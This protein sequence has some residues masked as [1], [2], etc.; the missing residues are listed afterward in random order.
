[1]M[2]RLTAEGDFLNECGAA[3]AILEYVERNETKGD[4]HWF[5]EECWADWSVPRFT[6]I[7]KCY[8]IPE[9]KDHLLSIEA[10]KAEDDGWSIRTIKRTPSTAQHGTETPPGPD[11]P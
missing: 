7:F 2:Q 1:M 3:S 11:S 10:T 4:D 6:V 5:F 9:Y 8:R